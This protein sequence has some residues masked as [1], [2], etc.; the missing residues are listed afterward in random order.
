MEAQRRAPGIQPSRLRSVGEGFLAAL[1]VSWLMVTLLMPLRLSATGYVVGGVLFWIEFIVVAVLVATRDRQTQ[2]RGIGEL[3][4][5]ALPVAALV[6]LAPFAQ[7]FTWAIPPAVVI[8]GGFV[9]WV[10]GRRRSPR[11]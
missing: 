3:V 1:V 4:A 9:V 6:I 5:L 2:L 7:A 8:G 10:T 11:P